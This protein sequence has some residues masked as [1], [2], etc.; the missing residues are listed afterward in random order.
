M[1]RAARAGRGGAQEREGR[2]WRALRASAQTLSKV[3]GWE[4]GNPAALQDGA[5]PRGVS[6]SAS[7]P[8][9]AAVRQVEV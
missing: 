2:I 7:A 8:A 5:T 6:L 9:G 3:P 4:C 1:L